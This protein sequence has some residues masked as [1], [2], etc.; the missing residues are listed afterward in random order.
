MAEGHQNEMICGNG[1]RQPGPGSKFCIYCG[2]ALTAAPPP[3]VITPPQAVQPVQP[4]LVQPQQFAPAV[5]PQQ[6]QQYPQY[7]QPV[8]QII[9]R[10]CGGYGQGLPQKSVICKECNWL[11]PLVPGYHVDSAAFEWAADAKAMAALRKIKPLNA[12]AKAVS[13]KVGRR[14]VEVAFNGVLLGE[15]QLPHIYGQ[16]VRA[17]RILGMSHMPDVY[18][19]GDRAWDCLT[20]GTD[21]DSFIILGSALAGNFQGVDLLFLLAREMGHCRAGHALWKT[22]IRFFLGEQGPAKGFMA[23][24]IFNAILSPT[25]L[26]SGAIEMPLL[27]WARQAEITADRAGMLAVGNEEVARRV[28]LSWSLR[29]SVMFRQLN[30]EEW[31]N[32]QEVED[33]AYVKL[34]EITTSSTPYIG[35]RLK[36]LAQYARSPEL[37]HY[38]NTI[39]ESI[40]RSAPPPKPAAKA[41]PDI[42]RFKCTTCGTPM[43]VPK[44]VL[45][46]KTVLPVK[47]PNAACGAITHLRKSVKEAKQAKVAINRELM[48]EDQSYAE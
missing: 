40:R 5:Q 12:A 2:V 9:C 4:P 32:Q 33:D 46:G 36:L 39:S 22:V 14:W 47:C 30:I 21:R 18:I 25:H 8:Q 16:A 29:S 45:D 48:G 44:E 31:I 10:T 7:Q 1:H 11:R 20:F 43:R 3:P 26:L 23:G 38:L 15:K 17:A 27:A 24:G 6:Y 35:P 13:E 41:N 19:S 28:L 34:S 37:K 42:L